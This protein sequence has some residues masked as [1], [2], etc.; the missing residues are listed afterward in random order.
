MDLW[1]Y[2]RGS[3]RV[4]LKSANLHGSLD[5]MG[6]AGIPLRDVEVIDEIT[7]RFWI[8]G[9]QVEAMG[10]LAEKRGDSVRFDQR[11]GLWWHITSLR[12]RP[13]LVLGIVF[14]LVLSLWLP[15]R[16]LFVR[17]EGNS[18]VP[19]RQIL[20]TAGKCGIAFGASR[21]EVRSEKVKNELL[22]EM[23]SLSWAGVNTYGSTAVISVRERKDTAMPDSDH[24]VCSIVASRDGIVEEITV[25]RG[26]GLCAAG[27]A[28]RAGQVLISGYTDCGLLIRA[29]RAEGEVFARTFR[30]LKVIGPRVVAKRGQKQWAEEKYSLIIGKKRI[31][32]A[33]NSGISGTDCAKIYV[34]NYWVLPGG[35]V[36][37]VALAVETWVSYETEEASWAPDL[38][39]AAQTYLLQQMISGSIQRMDTVFSE[40][41][42]IL[43]LNANCSCYEMIGITRIEERLSE[44]G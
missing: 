39:G 32:F 33:N 3:V 22:E 26:T 35:F 6:K 43:I 5:A 42:G 28:V 15:G 10:S 30:Q 34:E 7:A 24:R 17:V 31:N 8:P 25:I 4:R 44:H 9:G 29:T 37:P 18:L 20:E 11:M 14:L 38:Q 23:Q 12:K 21:R 41:E 27:Q 16:I 19:T 1:Q 13:V 2:L 40:E 36:L